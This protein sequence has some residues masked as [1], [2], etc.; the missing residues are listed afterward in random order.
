MPGSYLHPIG[1]ST[2]SCRKPREAKDLADVVGY[3]AGPQG[4]RVT[5][6]TIDVSGGTYLSPI[7]PA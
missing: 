2:L 5:G 3:L 6:Q 4:R 1:W 7:A